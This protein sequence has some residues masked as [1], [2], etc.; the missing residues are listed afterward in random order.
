MVPMN[1]AA[2]TMRY[3]EGCH[4]YAADAGN[5]WKRDTIIAA[6]LRGLTEERDTP[7]SSGESLD[8]WEDKC[9]YWIPDFKAV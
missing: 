7:G 4:G 9:R 5:T 1:S 6:A 3:L 8:W 2:D